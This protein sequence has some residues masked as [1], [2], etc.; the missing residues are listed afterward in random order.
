MNKLKAI[1][2]FLFGFKGRI[3]R[4]HFA[5][6][7]PFLV[8]S[9]MIFNMLAFVSS[10]VL[11]L[12]SIKQTNTYEIIQAIAILLISFVFYILLK[13][14]HIVRRVHDYNK[15]I[16]SSVLG[17]TIIICEILVTFLSL[18]SSFILTSHSLEDI[19]IAITLLGFI[20]LICL[21]SLIFIKGT[22]GE[23]QFG[24]EPIPF[25]K[26]QNSASQQE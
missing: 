7:L 11:A 8:I 10:K 18:L 16:G 2:N 17:S 15:S 12:S 26:K 5:I 3:G 19:Y 13:Y 4:L 22:K 1:W 9:F 23:N 21:I 25:W 14:S 20:G 24:K 6:F